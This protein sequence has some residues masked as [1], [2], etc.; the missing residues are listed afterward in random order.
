VAGLPAPLVGFP[1]GTLEALDGQHEHENRE[2]RGGY[3][4]ETHAATLGVACKRTVRR[5]KCGVRVP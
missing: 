1:Q 2:P 3:G 5:C 4:E